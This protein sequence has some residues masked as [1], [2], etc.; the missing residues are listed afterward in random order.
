MYC[1]SCASSRQA[2]FTAEVNLHFCGSY[3]LEHPGVLAFPKVLVCLDCGLSQ[4]TT[5]TTQLAD[6]VT[7]AKRSSSTRAIRRID[8]IPRSREVG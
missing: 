8:A 1:S 2:E 6:L 5:T 3:S 7:G 4:F